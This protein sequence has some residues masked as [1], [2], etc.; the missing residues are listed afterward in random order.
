MEYQSFGQRDL[1]TS[2]LCFGGMLLS[3][4]GSGPCKMPAVSD[5][6][7]SAVMLDC[8]V[9]AGG[10]FIDTSDS[11]EE[12]EAIIGRWLKKQSLNTRRKLIICTK[13]TPS[14]HTIPGVSALECAN[15]NGSSR[16][17]MM[18]AIEDS[19]EKLQTKYLDVYTIHY[20][21]D[22]T[23]MEE[24]LRTLQNLIQ[25]G[26]IRYYAVSNYTPVQLQ[27]LVSLCKTYQ[28]ELPIFIQTQYNLLCRAAEWEL[29]QLCKSHGIGFL[30]WS[31]LA[32]GWLSNKYSEQSSDK[33]KQPPKNS[34]MSFAES[35]HFGP[36]DLSTVGSDPKT[37]QVLRMCNDIAAE[38]KAT[39]SQVAV[40]WILSRGITGC[41]VGPR[42]LNHLE[43][44]LAALKL[45]LTPKHL[46]MLDD[47]THSSPIYPYCTFQELTVKSILTSNKNATHI[48]A[49]PSANY[50]LALQRLIEFSSAF[51]PTAN[52]APWMARLISQKVYEFAASINP[53]Y[54]S[55]LPAAK[56]SSIC[57]SIAP[58]TRFALTFGGFKSYEEP[59]TMLQ[60]LFLQLYPNMKIQ[61]F[62]SDAL[63]LVNELILHVKKECKVVLMNDDDNL[64]EW[65]RY[66][67]STSD[68]QRRPCLAVC[69]AI[70]CINQ[71]ILLMNLLQ[72]SNIS[73]AQ[74]KYHCIFSSGF[75]MGLIS[76]YAVENAM[77]DEQLRHNA[78]AAIRLAFYVGF[79]ASQAFQKWK[80]EQYA[81]KLGEIKSSLPIYHSKQ[82]D[83]KTG[84]FQISD[85]P[86]ESVI[87]AIHEFNNSN[88]YNCKFDVCL[89]LQSNCMAISGFSTFVPQVAR[90]LELRF[91]S[92]TLTS[93][94]L[95]V[96][97]HAERYFP[98]TA[99]VIVEDF[100]G[101]QLKFEG[102]PGQNKWNETAFVST[103]DGKLASN[104]TLTELVSSVL[105]RVCRWDL[106]SDQLAEIIHSHSSNPIV[107][108]DFGP[109]MR[110]KNLI[111]N[112][113]ETQ[114]QLAEGQ[115]TV[116][117]I[118]DMPLNALTAA[119]QRI[120]EIVTT[121]KLL[122][123]NS[124]SNHN[125]VVT[126]SIAIVGMACRF[127]DSNSVEEFYYNLLHKK[128]SIK[129]I[130]TERWDHSKYY[131]P[132]PQNIYKTNTQY[133]G[134]I[135]EIDFFDPQFFNLNI[136]DAEHMDPV[137]RLTLEMC[138][139]A[140]ESAGHV[141]QEGE[142]IGLNQQRVGVFVGCSGIDSY[143]KNME[144][145]LDA[146]FLQCSVRA[147]QAGR[148]SYFFKFC[149]PSIQ[150]DAACATSLV[151]V[152]LAV[153]S[154][155]RG[156]C[157]VAVVSA[158]MTSADPLEYMGLAAGGFFGHGG[159]SGC[160][161]FS[162][163]ADGYTRSDGAAAIILKP[164][165]T[166]LRDRDYIHA[167][168]N[169]T[170][171]NQS[172]Q[173]KSLLLPSQPQVESLI[174]T[175]LT[176]ACLPPGA[177]QYVE[178][179]G[180]GT[181]GGDPIEV[182]AIMQVL[183]MNA[184]RSKN[185]PLYIGA[186][187]A[188][189]GHCEAAAGLAGLIKTVMML[190]H[191]T[192]TP[193]IQLDKI[194][195]KINMQQHV[196]I[197]QLVQSWTVPHVNIP[198]R[199]V[200]NSFGF[201]GAN[202]SCVLQETP[203]IMNCSERDSIEPTHLITISAKHP[204][205][206]KAYC[207]R[208][209]QYLAAFQTK[210]IASSTATSTS[211][212][213]AELQFLRDLA[214]TTTARRNHYPH[215]I[216]VV[217]SSIKE[218]IG[219]LAH[220]VGSIP[221]Q[222]ERLQSELGSSFGEVLSPLTRNIFLSKGLEKV[223]GNA[224][225][226]ADS[227]PSR[228]VFVFGG[229]GS[230]HFG[231]CRQLLNSE[232]A[233][234]K[235]FHLCSELFA[236]IHPNMLPHNLTLVQ[237]LEAVHQ[238]ES[239]E[240]NAQN[241]SIV[242][243][244]LFHSTQICQPLLF[245]IQYSLGRMLMSWGFSPHYFI[246]HSVG[247]LVAACLGSVMSLEEAL[248]LIGHR[249]RLMGSTSKGAM[250][251]VNCTA[252]DFNNLCKTLHFNENGRTDVSIAC[253]NGARSIVIAGETEA[254]D[255]IQSY[256]SS[257]KMFSSS[258]LKV[259]KAFHSN[260]MAPILSEFST[261]ANKILYKMSEVPIIDTLNGQIR[262]TFNTKY[263]TQQ[264]SE[265][266]QFHSATS[267]LHALGVKEKF[268]PICIELN[269]TSILKQYLTEPGM[270]IETH[271]IL[272]KK[273]SDFEQIYSV[274]AQ[275]YVRQLVSI[276]WNELHRANWHARTLPLPSYVFNHR[277]CWL[278][279]PWTTVTCEN[280]KQSNSPNAISTTSDS[281]THELSL[282]GKC[283]IVV[284]ES[285]GNFQCS[286][287]VFDRVWR[288]D[289]QNHI[290]ASKPLLPLS[291]YVA[292]I[293]QFALFITERDGAK[294]GSGIYV[295]VRDLMVRSAFIWTDRDSKLETC[296][297]MTISLVHSNK[298]KKNKV[299]AS[300]Y[301][302]TVSSLE[303]TEIQNNGLMQPKPVIHASGTV[304]M[305]QSY[306]DN[307]DANK[308][309][310]D[311]IV[312]GL[313][314][315]VKSKDGHVFYDQNEFYRLSS[316]FGTAYGPHYRSME[317]FVISNDA[318]TSFSKQV[319]R[320][321][322][323][324]SDATGLTLIHTSWLDSFLHGLT[325][326]ISRIP[327]LNRPFVAMFVEN[328]FC[329]THVY[330][331]STT[332]D[333][334]H[335]QSDSNVMKS[336]SGV[337]YAESIVK[338][339]NLN[340]ITCDIRGFDENGACVVRWS[341]VIM[342]STNTGF[343]DR[344]KSENGSA[345]ACQLRS[346]QKNDK[347][348]VA[349]SNRGRDITKPTVQ[350]RA[351]IQKLITEIVSESLELDSTS[352]DFD[353]NFAQ[354]GIDSLLSIEIRGKLQQTLNNT[355][356]E[357]SVL[358]DYSSINELT[359]FISG[360]KLT[361]TPKEE[362]EETNDEE[363]D[364]SSSSATLLERNIRNVHSD[365]NTD[366]T[367]NSGGNTSN[368]NSTLSYDEIRTVLSTLIAES[369]E[370][371]SA[372]IDDDDR[373]V[374]MGVDSLL[375]IEI[376][377]KIQSSMDL[378]VSASLMFDY[379]TLKE[380]IQFIRTQLFP[381]TIVSEAEKD[382]VTEPLNVTNT[383][384]NHILSDRKPDASS[385]SSVEFINYSSDRSTSEFSPYEKS[386]TNSSLSSPMNISCHSLSQ[387]ESSS[388]LNDDTLL[389][390]STNNCDHGHIESEM[391]AKVSTVK[392]IHSKMELPQ[393]ISEPSLLCE[394]FPMINLCQAYTLG[395]FLP[396][397]AVRSHVLFIKSFRLD[398]DVEKLEAA[399]NQCIRR[400]PMLRCDIT[401]EF[402]FQILKEVPYYTIERF[403]TS[404]DA[405]QKERV[406]RLKKSRLDI[407][408]STKWP[409]V[410]LFAVYGP[411][412]ILLVFDADT[413][414]L[415]F[416]SLQILSE[417]L[418]LIYKNQS[419][420]LNN[421]SQIN[422]R[423]YVMHY[424]KLQTTLPLAQMHLK[425]WMNRAS[426]LPGGIDFP[427]RLD[428]TSASLPSQC[429]G[430]H[431]LTYSI[432]ASLWQKI[433]ACIRSRG[434]QASSVMCAV[435]ASILSI[436]C[437]INHFTLNYMFV[438][439]LPFHP[440]VD[441]LIG[442]LSSTLLLE[443]DFREPNLTFEQRARKMYQQFL[444]DLANS[445][446]CTAS[447]VVSILNNRRH[448][449]LVPVSSVAF[450]SLLPFDSS[451]QAF[452]KDDFNFTL[453]R[454]APNSE[455]GVL[456]TAAMVLDHQ[457]ATA[458]DGSLSMIFDFVEDL[459][460][461]N[462]L[463]NF[464]TCYI[465]K[466]TSLVSDGGWQTT[467]LLHRYNIHSMSARPLAG[468]KS[469]VTESPV[470]SEYNS[471]ISSKIHSF[472]LSSEI[473][474][475]G[476]SLKDAH[477][478][479][480][481]SA[482]GDWTL[483]Y[484][485]T[486]YLALK[487]ASQI[488]K[489]ILTKGWSN[490]ASVHIGI[491]CQRGWEQ[492]VSC[493][494]VTLIGAVF[495]PI[496]GELP[497]EQYKMRLNLA[498]IVLICTTEIISK[499]W[500]SK[501][502][503]SVNERAELIKV[504]AVLKENFEDARRGVV[505]DLEKHLEEINGNNDPTNTAYIIFTSGTTGIP[506][507]VCVSHVSAMNT[508]L[509][510]N[511]RIKLNY[512]DRVLALSH[513]SFDLSIWDIFGTL[514]G[515][516]TLVLL[517]QGEDTASDP[518]HWIE[519]IRKHQITVWNSVP[520]L[521]HL[522]YMAIDQR[523]IEQRSV[524]RSIRQV[525]LSGDWI[526]LSLPFKF[527]SLWKS[528]QNSKDDQ[529]SFQIFSLGGATECSIWSVFHRIDCE[530][531]PTAVPYTY[532]GWSSIP[533]GQPLNGQSLHILSTTLDRCPDG[534]SGQLYIGGI[535]LANCYYK[536]SVMT[537]QHF[538]IHPATHE[539]L[540]AT[541]DS[542]RFRLLGSDRVVEF[543]GR[544]KDDSQVKVQGYRIECAEIESVLCKLEYV[545]QAVVVVK[546]HLE[547]IK[548]VSSEVNSDSLLIAF[549]VCAHAAMNA[550]NNIAPNNAVL[551]HCRKF[552]P[553]YMIPHSVVFVKEIPR[554]FNGKADRVALL[555]LHSKTSSIVSKLTDAKRS[556]SS[557]ASNSDFDKSHMSPTATKLWS[558]WSRALNR[559]DQIVP[560]S[561][562]PSAASIFEFG[563]TSLTLL[564]LR[565]MV[566]QEFGVT[567][568]LRSFVE[569]PT[570]GQMEARI[571]H[572]LS[573]KDTEVTLQTDS[574][575]HSD[576]T[577]RSRMARIVCLH[578]AETP[579][580]GPLIFFH[581]STGGVN[582]YHQMNQLILERTCDRHSYAIQA[583][584]LENNETVETD[585]TTITQNNFAAIMSVH[586][587]VKG[588]PLSSL[589][590]IGFSSGGILACAVTQEFFFK[591][592]GDFIQ[593]VI[594]LDTP[595]PLTS[596]YLSPVTDERINSIVKQSLNVTDN[597]D[598]LSMQIEQL[599]SEFE[600][601]TVVT[602]A[603]L[604][605]IQKFFSSPEYPRLSLK[606]LK[607]LMGKI[608]FIRASDGYDR[609]DYDDQWWGWDKYFENMERLTI[610]NVDTDSNGK[611]NHSDVVN[612]NPSVSMT[613]PIW[614]SGTHYQLLSQPYISQLIDKLLPARQDQ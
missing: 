423:D 380:L 231:M 194:N 67:R 130:S 76:A 538:I 44:H 23:Q 223:E 313:D 368:S 123:E 220:V 20:W 355:D 474:R 18:D 319:I 12:S 536:N 71:F 64:F 543:L 272:H 427:R 405:E 320:Q 38:L 268:K 472:L 469:I 568:S 101:G 54:L 58:M 286:F 556:Q 305:T 62:I 119:A 551:E 245:A 506:K 562:E 4:N 153:E 104:I 72:S 361:Y 484:G 180:T 259:A 481:I 107:M 227:L 120:S 374:D 501:F 79:R 585:F 110:S 564:I 541:G 375:S 270:E 327:N 419:F 9:K 508:I 247:E 394:S 17:H 414:I 197:P 10:N 114:Q 233:W 343:S 24:V 200:V 262:T 306:S 452:S 587:L 333:R 519:I 477:R 597:S 14:V 63:E 357:P 75:N 266:V 321:D 429:P 555:S 443:F 353:E 393:I 108:L 344:Y 505:V 569:E 378:D 369:L 156:E 428:R 183:G 433:Q 420:K 57:A 126:S 315:D 324:Y 323:P 66:S 396:Q 489:S 445:S 282:I 352:I 592:A 459:L 261:I 292:L 338:I 552:L 30:A 42:S 29:I 470:K 583:F 252:D 301:A 256:I 468:P 424:R 385:T 150:I 596:H 49:S 178:A 444:A 404:S 322:Q 318:L 610:T 529:S 604:V 250:L 402:Y 216:A 316:E 196:V 26:I 545:Q 302:F 90:Y 95:D 399:W 224:A 34:R 2:R 602:K 45:K 586:T 236:M 458:A 453:D 573:R 348:T 570:L 297:E 40:R 547:D 239:S 185:N 102:T 230:Q 463:K 425:Y 504:D 365:E 493:L 601:I 432:D 442:N 303:R 362:Q 163:E 21:D 503:E 281:T 226:K 154:L 131:D 518:L 103:H 441:R 539:R 496:D 221:G 371:D 514:N 346:T 28:W 105:L 582:C 574:S 56:N 462:L 326:Q 307:I 294:L 456:E 450:V 118:D 164:Y 482:V 121:E 367:L 392:S 421:E 92:C 447:H 377:G 575:H 169:S 184:Y 264:L 437:D 430:F 476:T 395:Q 111:N 485:Q 211:F 571:L 158:A 203:A 208:F 212:S 88:Q 364:T 291:L 195:P 61:S 534:V 41:I 254:I 608:V 613:K 334:N 242:D 509:D 222:L 237:I 91:P 135:E 53:H 134:T 567:L 314:V 36:W 457:I 139:L 478:T 406:D 363:K 176:N 310:F 129:K 186:H 116:F 48:V 147:M 11:Y 179:H 93:L 69:M 80:V 500:N 124:G 565:S 246:G 65:L 516:S 138:Y 275:F 401:S 142:R 144:A 438:N 345:Q 143:R 6:P 81:I 132:K 540:Y 542:A 339:N 370:I 167:L 523:E 416:Y 249:A 280:Q 347:H 241:N 133:M 152:H 507:A 563:A 572:E 219:K 171:M 22:A 77:N 192:I 487:L 215:R 193:H 488:Q 549:I 521:L 190:Q 170:A 145:H 248:Y 544:I 418:L 384:Y 483:S 373:F 381:E 466:V 422:Y 295:T 510:I 278:N 600:R 605:A 499:K 358:F 522:L 511:V 205:S 467:S 279:L 149:G 201:S 125:D 43:D 382:D 199:A 308:A 492:I 70:I 27:Q 473:I 359:N 162:S 388:S 535:G 33:L 454:N 550:E 228:I 513:L 588:S 234:S 451:S 37:W 5:E 137:Q 251:A 298:N 258:K 336:S 354:M 86:Y 289:I 189:T 612:H 83:Y 148:V 217:A 274:V 161:A 410:H 25:M 614:T 206:V 471:T 165:K 426:T 187:K 87:N 168:I 218:L 284:D 269:P 96:P 98:E 340:R 351:A 328:M 515:G 55:I 553:H 277:S 82:L 122:I 311:R 60:Q 465:D 593:S 366:S 411:K 464:I 434:L 490:N 157:D 436:F 486:L 383:S 136:R 502:H 566:Q 159:G 255:T 408:M 594:L 379:P 578:R 512:H 225:T 19:L 160:R 606:Q 177:I 557:T 389:A 89:V 491:T 372:V 97:M 16:K 546:R 15:S 151:C 85:V 276:S 304:C 244:Q 580:A 337:F 202:A 78:L 576:A 285:N 335:K 325:V 94:S 140:L 210:L 407:K 8:Y 115:L 548:N 207:L 590:L 350:D 182:N 611:T 460:A 560:Q 595:G 50:S 283:R 100:M 360:L 415:D 13:F 387:A 47:V 273:Q 391:H 260:F 214:Y 558:I 532:A 440:D 7:T 494:A 232:N 329:R 99:A 267:A 609:V 524:V 520:Q 603:N 287:P 537:D 290:V 300:S 413:V 240:N 455:Y 155:L 73:L 204:D 598:L 1:V 309:S 112:N 581:P 109:A 141:I 229:Q 584:G 431:S 166:A 435:F 376:R 554:S 288:V 127:P 475:L 533:Y 332:I 341:G 398:L 213:V 172:G 479:A 31:P 51:K 386:M 349:T 117:T 589:T 397:M 400:H 527:Y 461:E 517:D 531:C 68:S 198:R 175:V 74:L 446:F 526:P 235:T 342:M 607:I 106:V 331:T 448:A 498:D 296:R 253:Y 174:R 356:L 188:F 52:R 599:A 559:S 35:V 32:G 263:W 59:V 39:V 497:M 439:R 84:S 417:E 409:M 317:R 113:K 238:Y 525:M 243:E 528:V 330:N 209:I 561:N 181:A 265:A 579:V 257:T 403:H 390:T 495:V 3:S 412:K 312:M 577:I 449:T 480:L 299:V 128:N 591:D 46:A 293:S 173:A 191:K 530:S 271:P 146:Y